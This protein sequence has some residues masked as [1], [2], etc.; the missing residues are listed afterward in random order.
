MAKMTL[1]PN[2]QALVE[3]LLML[4]SPN[5]ATVCPQADPGGHVRTRVRS[6]WHVMSEHLHASYDMA[7]HERNP[8]H[9]AG[10]IIE[11]CVSSLAC[12]AE[13]EEEPD[14]FMIAATTGRLASRVMDIFGDLSPRQ[15]QALAEEMG[16]VRPSVGRARMWLDRLL[17]EA[18]EVHMQ[19]FSLAREWDMPEGGLVELLDQRWGRPRKMESDFF[20]IHS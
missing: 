12:L 6:F 10:A 11:S 16:G 18:F 20:P 3:L 15:E 1:T 5:P 17:R 4:P 2:E 19:M 9:H 14:R 13:R 7:G 8:A